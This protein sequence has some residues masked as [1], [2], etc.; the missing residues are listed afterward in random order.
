MHTETVRK[1]VLNA[2]FGAATSIKISAKRLK[3]EKRER[4]VLENESCDYILC[5][6]INDSRVL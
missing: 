6:L 5:K 3:K 2:L 4:K 1:G